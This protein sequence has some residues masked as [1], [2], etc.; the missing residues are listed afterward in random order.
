VIVALGIIANNVITALEEFF[1]GIDLQT[2]RF[3]CFGEDFC[4]KRLYIVCRDHQKL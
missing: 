3:V 2:P 1:K 4:C